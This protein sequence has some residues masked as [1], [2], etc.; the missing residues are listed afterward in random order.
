MVLSG[1]LMPPDVVSIKPATVSFEPGEGVP[2]PTLTLLPSTNELLCE[3]S[4]LAPIAV[5][6]VRLFAPRLA[7][8]PRMVLL[9]PVVLASPAWKPKNELEKPVVLNCPA[10]LPAN[11]LPL[12]VRLFSPAP[13]PKKV[14]SCPVVFLK[15]A[16][17]P[18]NELL[19]A[20]VFA[21]PELYP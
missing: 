13:L 16:L 11:V 3:T 14:L 7:P 8:L 5:A 2:I 1:N 6:F 18:K 4:A 21:A 19:I 17:C 10:R 20:V 9:L 15:P 12:A